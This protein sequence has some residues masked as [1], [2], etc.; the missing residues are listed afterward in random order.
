[1]IYDLK[2]N[3]AVS[4]YDYML[5]VGPGYLSAKRVSISKR[6]LYPMNEY[7][8]IIQNLLTLKATISSLELSLRKY[9]IIQIT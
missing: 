3:T 8:N 7:F 2:H 9:F 6:T 4:N 5:L 1:M